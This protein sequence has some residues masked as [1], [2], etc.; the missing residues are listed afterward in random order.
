MVPSVVDDTRFD[1]TRVAAPRSPLV[2]EAG[3]LV[4]GKYRIERLIGKGAMGAVHE[5]VHAT[6]AAIVGASR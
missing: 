5:G 1:L 3:A 2:I 6:A 4:D